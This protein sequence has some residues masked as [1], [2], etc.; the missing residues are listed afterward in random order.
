M[1]RQR[2]EN[3]VFFPKVVPQELIED[4]EQFFKTL[5]TYIKSEDFI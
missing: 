1:Q 2:V 3:D 5:S 4:E